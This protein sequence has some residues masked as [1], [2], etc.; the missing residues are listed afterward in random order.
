MSF[1]SIYHEHKDLVFNLA[2]QYVQNIEDAEEITQDVFVTVHEKRNSFRQESK[3]STWIYRIAINKSLDHIK[4]RKRQKRFAFFTSLFHDETVK[5]KHDV[6]DFIHPGILMEQK[7][8]L[9]KL[10]GLINELPDNQKTILI[11]MKIEGKTQKEVAEIMDI[12]TKAVESLF[13]RAK[14]NLLKKI[15]P[16]E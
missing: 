2:L 10:F 16:T 8:E 3:L 4:A 12:S 6:S 7:E 9:E 1:E 15:D 13:H 11:L 14:N 5:I